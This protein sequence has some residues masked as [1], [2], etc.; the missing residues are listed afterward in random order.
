MEYGI[1]CAMECGMEY[2]IWNGSLVHF[3]GMEY[4]IGDLEYV[5]CIMEYGNGMEMNRN[6]MDNGMEMG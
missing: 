5:L 1:E 3:C 6:G 2:G 4:G